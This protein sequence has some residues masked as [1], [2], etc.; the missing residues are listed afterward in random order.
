MRTLPKNGSV[1]AWTS[2]TPDE[3]WAIVADVT[4]VG[5]WSHECIGAR[6]L[7][8]AT[9]ARPGA[10]F[11]GANTVSRARWS[12][13]CEIAAADAPHRLVWRTVPTRWFRDSTEW[14]IRLDPDDDG[15]RITQTFH[16]VKIGPVMD[17]LYYLLTPPHRDRSPALTDDV[18]RLARLAAGNPSSMVDG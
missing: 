1:E 18:R 4:R 17:R 3:V 8:G 10:R 16:V 11:S 14:Q 9:A 12:R 13:V 5:E 6:W 7:D 2:A 15:T